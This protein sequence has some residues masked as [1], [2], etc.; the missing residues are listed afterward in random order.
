MRLIEF[1]AQ[2][3]DGRRREFRGGQP[4]FPTHTH[5]GEKLG[6]F[7]RLTYGWMWT[8]D[9]EIARIHAEQDRREGRD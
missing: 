8:D 6:W 5:T 3:Y 7:G 2:S 4:W 9:P 1:F